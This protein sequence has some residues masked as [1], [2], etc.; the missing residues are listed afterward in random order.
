MPTNKQEESSSNLRNSTTSSN[1]AKKSSTSNSYQAEKNK[2]KDPNQ[3][4][5]KKA[6]KVG[7]KAAAT[8]FGGA[9]GG[10]AVDALAKTPQG[11]KIL[12][13]GG[14]LLGHIPG[15]SQATKKLDDSGSLD[16]ADQALSLSGGSLGENG[17][18][19]NL[20]STSKNKDSPDFSSTIGKKS[21]Q[22]KKGLTSS[23]GDDSYDVSGEEEQDTNLLGDL[24]SSGFLWKK[25]KLLIIGGCFLVFL[26]MGAGL[27]AVF[28]SA[29]KQNAENDIG[30]PDIEGAKG[31]KYESQINEYNCTLTSN[32]NSSS[33]KK[34]RFT[35]YTGKSLGG[36]IGN[37]D[38]YIREGSIYYENGY[39]MWKGGTRSKLNGQVY[40]QAG[41]NYMIVATAT[42]YI[43]GNCATRA[44]SYRWN[45]D[46]RINYFNY[47]DTF[48]VEISFD[49]GSSYIP[50]N[51]IVLDSC[52][53]CMEW[54]LTASGI[55]APHST[56]SNELA[57]CK[58]SE[59]YKIDLF[60]REANVLGKSDMGFF[61]HGNPSNT[62]VGEVD[63]GDL[64]VGTTDTK[65]LQNKSMLDLYGN[66]GMQELSNQIKSNAE[67]YGSGTGKGVAAAAITLINSLKSKGYRLP[68]YWAG[69]HGA[70]S[71]GANPSWG[72]RTGGSYSRYGTSYYYNSLDCSGFVSWAIK[73]GGCT[74]FNSARSSSG[75]GSIGPKES[76]SQVKAGDI[77]VYPGN[78]VVL[79]VQ[80]NAG[81][82][83]LAESSGGSGGVHYTSYNQSSYAHNSNYYFIDM[84]KFY[85]ST[86][87]K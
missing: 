31:T 19:S 27:F 11:D 51:A 42:K 2:G 15:M 21:S 50:Y 78:H 32:T 76:V 81:N 10:K 68:Y 52:G 67:K 6:A 49:G 72:S 59:G 35:T 56:N 4:S 30:T 62:C 64:V 55:Y 79:V 86:S 66:G 8:Y 7:A 69:G 43:V 26:F 36:S 63:L 65:L 75:F 20:D 83:I 28:G 29:D 45:E 46:S 47:G 85:S 12:N 80:N 61:L 1:N 48:T 54:S 73:N 53:A 22:K 25:K 44:C 82:I 84:S 23:F 5:N 71:N 39:A 13:R 60:R 77:L 37:V 14:E 33:K 70:I 87:C 57:K 38:S 9:A 24:F 58:E 17:A 40:G 16:K 34:A 3:D 41:T 74:N 18:P